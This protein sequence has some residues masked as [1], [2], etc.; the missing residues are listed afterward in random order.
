MNR[1]VIRVNP[2]REMVEMQR[3][4]DRFFDDSWRPYANGNDDADLGQHEGFSLPVDVI[5]RDNRF[6]ISAALPGTADDSIDISIDDNVLHIV[7]ELPAPEL[8]DGERVVLNE[9]RYGKFVRSLRLN[10][11]VDVD[12]VAATYDNG[13]LTLE[14]PFVP[15]VQPR[16]IG[17]RRAGE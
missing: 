6:I 10:K 13:V 2:I 5:E 9:R 4:L 17:I 15:E 16:K 3:A 11:P 14:L 7:A 1:R 8:A 12:N